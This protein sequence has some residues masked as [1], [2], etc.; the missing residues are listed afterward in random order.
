MGRVKGS[1]TKDRSID[2]EALREVLKPIYEKL[3]E[4][5]VSDTDLPNNEDLVD[6]LLDFIEEKNVDDWATSYA[7]WVS[8]KP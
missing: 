4:K 6:R 2:A 1:I 8:K 5:G 3:R 7:D